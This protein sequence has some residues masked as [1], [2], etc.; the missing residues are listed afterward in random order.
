MTREEMIA[1]LD[2]HPSYMKSAEIAALL[3]AAQDREAR[4]ELDLADQ[5]LSNHYEH[6]GH[7]IPP[8]PHKHLCCWELPP[9][10]AKLATGRIREL[11]AAVLNPIHKGEG[12]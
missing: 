4:L 8:W 12:E 1:W 2:A 6:C 7:E 10:L 3:R 11:I 5:W 9:T